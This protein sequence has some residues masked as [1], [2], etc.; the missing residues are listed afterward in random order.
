MFTFFLV[1]DDQREEI[2]TEDAMI[3]SL[4][5]R[6]H[7]RWLDYKWHKK[8]SDDNWIGISLFTSFLNGKE[9]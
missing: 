7:R 9:L 5:K 6:L 3:G 2:A 8:R 1:V 4:K